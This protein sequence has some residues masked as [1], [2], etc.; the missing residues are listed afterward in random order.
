MTHHDIASSA[1]PGHLP[2]VLLCFSISPATPVE[3]CYNIL[4]QNRK[5]EAGKYLRLSYLCIWQPSQQLL[6]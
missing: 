3:S 2:L 4:K 6:G 5:G 1:A